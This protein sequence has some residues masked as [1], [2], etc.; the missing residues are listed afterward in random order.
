M[1]L[2]KI[3]YS[4]KIFDGLKV[5]SQ[6]IGNLIMNIPITQ[7]LYD[8]LTLLEPAVW[9]IIIPNFANNNIFE[10][11]RHYEF[12]TVSSEMFELCK[13]FEV[14]VS[15]QSNGSH[16]LISALSPELAVIYTLHNLT[17]PRL[18]LALS[19]L[20][21]CNLDQL[22]RLIE[23]YHHDKKRILNCLFDLAYVPLYRADKVWEILKKH[24]YQDI[25]G[26]FSLYLRDFIKREYIYEK[27][28]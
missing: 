16:I 24:K 18:F 7:N 27:I 3:G 23:N 21:S 6:K 25:L 15:I 20:R 22:K 14:K 8:N 26:R 2:K 5:L 19:M 13:R 9:E 1:V 11:R 4:A 10:F 12:I 17:I 28:M